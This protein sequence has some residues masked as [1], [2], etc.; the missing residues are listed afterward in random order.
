MMDW[1]KDLPLVFETPHW[2]WLLVIAPV[3]LV[4]RGQSGRTSSL[5]YPSAGLVLGVS[6]KVHRH[7]GGVPGL[8]HLIKIL[9]LCLLVVALARPKWRK[10]SVTE[11]E[12][13]G[14]DIVLGLDLS[15]SMWA[16]DFEVR[17]KP[18]DRLSV[19]K[20]VIEEFIRE[21]PDD[22]SIAAGQPHA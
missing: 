19:V 10:G 12:R 8:L 15:G 11:S 21:R 17:N 9:S 20:K 3:L 16:H 14:V 13:S 4:L 1:F 2:L 18:T 6:R 7:W 22:R 5:L